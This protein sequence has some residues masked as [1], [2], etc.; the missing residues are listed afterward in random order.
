MCSVAKVVVFFDDILIVMIFRD[1]ICF[2]FGNSGSLCL[3]VP[4]VPL[5]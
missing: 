5:V 2:G 3:D 1:L 4:L